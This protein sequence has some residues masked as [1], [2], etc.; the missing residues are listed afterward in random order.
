MGDKYFNFKVIFLGGVW[1][2]KV[3]IKLICLR[4]V[5]KINTLISK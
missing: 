2:V 1:E 5:K 4:G 3:V